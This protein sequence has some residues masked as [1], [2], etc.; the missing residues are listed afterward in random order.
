MIFQKNN[1]NS[2]NNKDYSNNYYYKQSIDNNN[3]NYQKS[4]NSLQSGEIDYEYEKQMEEDYYNEQIKQW[5]NE[6]MK[7]NK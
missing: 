4:L 5:E 2:N 7:K 6:E 1:N 3:L